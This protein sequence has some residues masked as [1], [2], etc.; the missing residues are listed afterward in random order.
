MWDKIQVG[1][2]H[3]FEDTQYFRKTHKPEE[4]VPQNSSNSAAVSIQ[5]RGVTDRL[6]DADRQTNRQTETGAHS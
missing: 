2:A 4:T 1:S 3:T 5:C 6:D